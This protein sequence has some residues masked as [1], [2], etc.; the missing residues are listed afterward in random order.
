MFTAKEARLRTEAVVKGNQLKEVEKK[1]LD[2]ITKGRST[3][4]MPYLSECT[5][6][7]LKAL[8]YEINFYPGDCMNDAEYE[9]SW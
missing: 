8:G 7:E 6:K 9:I 3:I 5:I 2:A 4:I 1:M